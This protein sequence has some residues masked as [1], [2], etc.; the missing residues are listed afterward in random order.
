MAEREGCA[1]EA[2]V[3]VVCDE[4]GL[5]VLLVDLLERERAHAVVAIAPSLEGEGPVIA[6]AGVRGVVGERTHIYVLDGECV[7]ERLEA[8]LGRRLA[9]AFGAARVWWPELSARGDPGDHPHVLALA[10]EDEQDTLAEF[11]RQFVCV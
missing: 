7:L 10:G 11:A 5:G 8:E 9:L 4:R 6:P 2:G 1:V 3:V